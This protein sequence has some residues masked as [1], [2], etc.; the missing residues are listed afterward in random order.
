MFEENLQQIIF[1]P[2][3]TK[4]A[5]IFGGI[6]LFYFTI[7]FLQK[8]FL[9]K[10]KDIDS[11]YKVKKISSFFYYFLV[12]LLI[13]IV[14]SDKIRG[15]SIAFGVAGAGVAFALQEVITSIAG[16][17]AIMFGGLY[18]SGD[19]IQIG[20]VKG[21]VMDIGVLRTTIMEIGD[22]VD[23]DLYNGK[24]VYISNNFVFKEP[25]FNYSSDFPFLWDELKICLSHGSNYEKAKEILR[26]ASKE[27]EDEITIESR[28]KWELMQRKFLLEDA[29][30]EPLITMSANENS[31]DFTL[32]YIV[33]YKKRRVTKDELFTKILSEI[34]KTKGEVA[35]S[36]SILRL[37][38]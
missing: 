3:A 23:G 6:C 19:R 24:I 25:V 17:V 11:R 12:T 2:L 21:D 36:T 35:F 31:V 8:K 5:I 29:K 26:L 33:N 16:W 32:R 1:N 38:R 37:V 13:A 9:I 22:W 18:K 14:F 27:V 30:L 10:I 34:E 4:L 28:K 7:K 15:L 20:A